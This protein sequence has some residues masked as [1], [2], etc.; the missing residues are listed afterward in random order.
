MAALNDDERC[1]LEADIAAAEARAPRYS[2]RLDALD[3]VFRPQ[4]L[5]AT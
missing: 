1:E 4:K 2:Q 3:V 5:I